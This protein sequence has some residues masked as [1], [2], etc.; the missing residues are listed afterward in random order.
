MHCT[1]LLHFIL[2]LLIRLRSLKDVVIRNIN[3]VRTVSAGN[4][5]CPSY[6]V[7]SWIFINNQKTTK[8][9]TS[10]FSGGPIIF[11][12]EKLNLLISLSKIRR[13]K[14]HSLRIS[15]RIIDAKWLLDLDIF[16]SPLTCVYRPVSVA[17][18][19]ASS[20]LPFFVLCNAVT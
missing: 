6:L 3:Q 13:K 14:R 12:L 11:F 16:F 7:Y 18:A 2:W 4:K 10:I 8:N 9:P 19:I 15:Q 17:H 5:K 1:A 20:F